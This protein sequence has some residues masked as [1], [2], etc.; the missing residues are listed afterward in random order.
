MI[1]QDIVEGSR[2][3]GRSTRNWM[4]DISYFSPRMRQLLTQNTDRV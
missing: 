2:N 1:L 4:H 3:R